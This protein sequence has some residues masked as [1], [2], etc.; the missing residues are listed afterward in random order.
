[1]KLFSLVLIGNCLFLNLLV[2]P[3]TA[4][5]KSEEDSKIDIPLENIE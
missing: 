4:Q 2:P 1:M 5:E 3:A